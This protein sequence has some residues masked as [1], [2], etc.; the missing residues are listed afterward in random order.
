MSAIRIGNQTTKH[1]VEAFQPYYFAL[2]HGFD[3]FEWF[4]DK[5][6]YGWCEDD[7]DAAGR[8]R[9]KAEGQARNIRFSVHAP[10]FASPLDPEG[11]AALARSIAFAA[12]IGAAVV[13]LHLVTDQGPRAFADALAPLVEQARTAGVTLSLENTPETTPDDFNAVFAE[14]HRDGASPWVVGMCFDMGHANLCHVTRH[15]YCGYVDLLS[16]VVPIIHW[17]AHE[18]WGDRDSHLT[19]FTGPS[20]H[21]DAGI[22]GLLERLLRRGFA[23]SVILEQWP[24]PPELLARARNRLRSLIEELS[25]S[26]P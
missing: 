23:G 5:G 9:L 11:R 6:R 12:D 21:S 13:N 14:L 16:E 20:A 4:S 25:R 8:V 2:E 7:H 3:A 19:L 1:I 24:E 26:R 18:N 15:D 22:R 10:Y 17:H